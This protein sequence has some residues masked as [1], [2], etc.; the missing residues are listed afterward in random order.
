MGNEGTNEDDAINALVCIGFSPQDGG[1]THPLTIRVVPLTS[2][3]CCCHRITVIADGLPPEEHSV[4]ISL[5]SSKRSPPSRARSQGG[6][7][8]FRASGSH[9]AYAARICQIAITP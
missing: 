9:V 3:D 4:A 2:Q 8:A 6:R 1:W 7:R 5:L